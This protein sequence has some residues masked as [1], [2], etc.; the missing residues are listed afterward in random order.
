[1][2]TRDIITAINALRFRGLEFLTIPSSYYVNLKERL[3]QSKVKVAESLEILEK[4][5]ILVD[6]DDDGYLLQIFSKPCQD[7]PT[8][9]IEIIQ[10]ENFQVD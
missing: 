8:L 7:R 3:A 2:N 4:L 6:F 1:L 9:F 5:H 10:R